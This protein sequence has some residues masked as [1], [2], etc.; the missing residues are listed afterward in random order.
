M[1]L[2]PFA[3]PHRLLPARMTQR[4]VDIIHTSV[5]RIG[6]GVTQ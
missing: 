4:P 2:H 3:K 1:L 5:T 6:P